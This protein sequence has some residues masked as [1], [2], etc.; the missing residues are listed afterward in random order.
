MNYYE[1]I[2]RI[3]Y[4]F[5]NSLEEPRDNA[6]TIIIDAGKAANYEEDTIVGKAR[7][8]VIEEDC[9]QYE[10]RFDNAYVTYQVSNE[11]FAFNNESDQYEG[12]VIRVYSRS[13]Y[14]DYTLQHTF[15]NDIF[16]DRMKHYSIVC[17]NHVID[18]IA[19]G[20]PVITK[21]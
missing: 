8:V 2:N 18:V 16:P 7:P 1:E 9:P 6:L 4:V 13:A 3:Q 21:R 19:F 17:Q 14:M 11:S 10:I 5:L 15:A 12:K 20:E